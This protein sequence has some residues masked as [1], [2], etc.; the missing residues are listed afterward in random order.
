MNLIKNLFNKKKLAVETEEATWRRDKTVPDQAFYPSNN[1]GPL[2]RVSNDNRVNSPGIR[3]AE[4]YDFHVP[5]QTKASNINQPAWM[6]SSTRVSNSEPQSKYV[7]FGTTLAAPPVQKNSSRRI[8]STPIDFDSSPQV[9]KYSNGNGNNFEELN[10]N[11]LSE[12]N[13]GQLGDSGKF[14]PKAN[15]LTRDQEFRRNRGNSAYRRRN[16]FENPK[17]KEYYELENRI[18]RMMV[19]NNQ[20]AEAKTLAK[21][22]DIFEKQEIQYDNPEHMFKEFPGSRRVNAQVNA[23]PD[24]FGEV[25]AQ[26]NLT[27]R[28]LKIFEGQTHTSDIDT[29]TNPSGLMTKPDAPNTHRSQFTQSKKNTSSTIFDESTYD[30]KDFDELMKIHHERSIELRAL[31]DRLISQHNDPRNITHL[32]QSLH[33]ITAKIDSIKPKNMYAEGEKRLL[34]EDINKKQMALQAAER[35]HDPISSMSTMELNAKE[36]II[37][38]IEKTQGKIARCRAEID[39][40][41]ISADEKNKKWQELSEKNMNYELESMRMNLSN[42]DEDLMRELK[43]FLGKYS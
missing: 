36:A 17:L 11:P 26:P 39:K 33:E 15:G 29:T 16:Q 13:F 8:L 30:G 10:L 2:D 32:E 40:F 6:V 3:Q 28:R 35:Q 24:I 19:L 25:K 9:A 38:D 42:Y 1:N 37:R 20:E 22:I 14:M 41:K 23:K 31:E 43:Y 18:N 27:K 5:E 21:P 7:D 34:T 12:P 4:D